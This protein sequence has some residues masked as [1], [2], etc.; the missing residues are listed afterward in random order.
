MRALFLM[1]ALLTPLIAA[2]TDRY[3]EA[4]QLLLEA[5]KSG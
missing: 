3:P 5:E 2:E 1:I 4:K